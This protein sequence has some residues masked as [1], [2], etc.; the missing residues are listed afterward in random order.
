MRV[1]HTI[2]TYTVSTVEEIA[3]VLLAARNSN[4]TVEL[5]QERTIKSGRGCIQQKV[6]V[7][8]VTWEGTPY[9]P[10]PIDTALAALNRNTTSPPAHAPA[11]KS[12]AAD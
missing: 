8:Y 12:I 11:E 7:I 6:T 1:K 5:V 9:A 10:N 4:G 2:R 3:A